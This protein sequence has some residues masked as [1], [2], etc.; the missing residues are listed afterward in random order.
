MAYRQDPDLDFLGHCSSEELADLVYLLTFDKDSKPRLTEQLSKSDK[1]K[2]YYPNHK[3]YWEEIAEEVQ[4][5]GGNTISNLARLGK[6]IFYR[7][8]LCDVCDKMKIKYE[9]DEHTHIIELKLLEKTLEK[10]ASELP[11]EELKEIA[12][13]L[14][15]PN[16]NLPPS[17]LLPAVITGLN[18]LLSISVP[19]AINVILDVFGTIIGRKIVT[20]TIGTLISTTVAGRALG[21]AAGP[22]GW[23]ISGAWLLKDI[24]SPAMRVTIPA[25]IQ[26]ALLR[27][28]KIQNA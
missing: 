16:T 15:L 21:I 20:T 28:K 11:E 10:I 27:A 12:K 2:R 3:M 14:D 23:G 4:L 24:A 9:K 26:I 6:G 7:E 13:K 25:V 18:R 19:V 22:I 1:Y 8:I 5:F 17:L